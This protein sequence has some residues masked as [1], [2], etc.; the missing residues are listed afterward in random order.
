[1]RIL[2]V[3]D[4]AELSEWLSR[5][6]RKSHYVVDCVY[7]GEEADAALRGQE[8]AL[9]LLDLGLPHGDG[10]SVLNH[11]RARNRSVP[12]IILTANDAI[13]SRVAGL[14]GGADDYLVK[15][16]DIHELEARIRARLRHNLPMRDNIIAFG[17]V[18][19]DMSA[20]QFILDGKALS[21]S[22]REYAVLQA[23]ILRAGKPLQKGSLVETV[24][25][26]DDEANPSAIEIYVHRVRKKLEGSGVGIVTL[27]GLG[28]ALAKAG[29]LA[30][31]PLADASPHAS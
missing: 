14:D 11:L 2:L 13:S 24:F 16:V 30:A 22:P 1:M 7:S 10:M 9:V 26:F 12:V 21:L 25:G 19:L 31:A 4:N 29:P 6:L 20:S 5:L 27:R 18:S 28:Y 8:Y 3:E 15:P 23:L 17:P